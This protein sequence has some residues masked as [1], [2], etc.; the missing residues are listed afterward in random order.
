[1]IA[2]RLLSTRLRVT[3]FATLFIILVAPVDFF[4]LRLV[5]FERVLVVRRAYRGIDD[6]G[7]TGPVDPGVDFGEGQVAEP[8]ACRHL[9]VALKLVA[10]AK[11]RE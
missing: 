5:V 4:V 6:Y 9:G 7:V 8:L 2:K 11:K 10:G 3:L 1:M